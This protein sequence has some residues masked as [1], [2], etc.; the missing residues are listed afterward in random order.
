MNT[1]TSMLMYLASYIPILQPILFPSQPLSK[2]LPPFSPHGWFPLFK[3]CFLSTCGSHPFSPTQDS[4]Y[5]L[6][7]CLFF[8]F[9]DVMVILSYTISSHFVVAVSFLFSTPP[10]PQKVSVSIIMLGTSCL[11]IFFLQNVCLVSPPR[12]RR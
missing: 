12:A 6:Q 9:L 7:D 4:P 8:A 3:P 1:S 11:K 10:H 5:F 2:P